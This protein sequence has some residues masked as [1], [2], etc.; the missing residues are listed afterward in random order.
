MSA[1]LHLTRERLLLQQHPESGVTSLEAASQVVGR[2]LLCA[3]LRVTRTRRL[4][5]AH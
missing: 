5:R 1:C 2:Q 4:V 3:R